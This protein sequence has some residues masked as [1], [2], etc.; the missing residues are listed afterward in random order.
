MEQPFQDLEIFKEQMARNI[1]R[2]SP[3]KK[4]SELIQ[5]DKDAEIV[6]TGLLKSHMLDLYEALSWQYASREV[7]C[8]LLQIYHILIV[9]RRPISMCCP[10]YQFQTNMRLS[11]RMASR[12]WRASEDA[13]LRVSTVF[14]IDIGMTWSLSIASAPEIWSPACA[15][16]EER[17]EILKKEYLPGLAREHGLS[18]EFCNALKVY[19]VIC[20]PCQLTAHD[21]LL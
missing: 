20:L 8:C 10:L 11:C 18:K 12:M 2:L 4:V 21:C 7:G 14:I 15:A 1:L 13:F 9:M 19:P 5:A 3:E 16:C 6:L 17:L